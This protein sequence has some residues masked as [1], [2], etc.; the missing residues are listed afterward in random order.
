MKWKGTKEPWIANFDNNSWLIQNLEDYQDGAKSCIA[1]VYYFDD[2]ED[3][4]EHNAQLIVD[5]GNVRQ[6]IN[7]DLPELLRQRNE[8]L[9]ML[10]SIVKLS[11]IYESFRHEIINDATDMVKE[12]DK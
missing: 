2:G 12:F 3:T 4:A 1:E 6:Q 7:F 9:E 10:K 11:N 5:A 8:M